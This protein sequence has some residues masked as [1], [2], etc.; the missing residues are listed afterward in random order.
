MGSNKRISTDG[1]SSFMQNPFAKLKSDGLP[2]GPKVNPAKPSDRPVAE[3]VV[4]LTFDQAKA[5]QGAQLYQQY[6]C[7][8]CHSTTGAAGAGPSFKG[9]YGSKVR[10][11]NGA[12]V[13]ADEAYIRESILQPDAKTVN[14][15]SKG[16]MVGA[17]GPKLPDISQ[18][19]NLTP[20]VEFV[21]SLAK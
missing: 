4:P 9:V 2:P 3:A 13:T 15:F 6:G 11:D 21:K 20:L 14:G 1:A 12:A 5:D 16:V 10:L 8:S 17:I 19:Q 18:P 7:V